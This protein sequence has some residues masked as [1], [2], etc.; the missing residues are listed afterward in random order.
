MKHL[1]VEPKLKL[2]SK[3][4]DDCVY[5]VPELREFIFGHRLKENTMYGEQQIIS[6]VAIPLGEE[7]Q[8]EF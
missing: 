3:L 7:D 6:V 5:Y 2:V 1:S 8:N 4:V